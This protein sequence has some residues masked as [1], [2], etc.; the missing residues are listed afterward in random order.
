MMQRARRSA[1]GTYG[2]FQGGFLVDRGVRAT[3]RIAPLD[4][5][6]DFP[7]QWPIVLFISKRHSG[8]FGSDEKDAFCKLPDASLAERDEMID[9]TRTKIVPGIMSTDYN[10]FADGVYEFGHRCGQ[11]F[12]EL[13]GGPFNGPLATSLVS[14]IRDFGVTAVGQ[15]SWGPCIFG[16]ARNDEQANQ[17]VTHIRNSFDDE[18]ETIVTRADNRG[19]VINTLESKISE[20]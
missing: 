8:L 3:E 11:F 16:C 10:L 9:L 7:T 1:I 2:F 6:I 20:S 17:L 18:I 19:H 14:A 13:Q 5:R 12:S 4:I 15:S